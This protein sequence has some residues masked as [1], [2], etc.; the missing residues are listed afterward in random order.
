MIKLQLKELRGINSRFYGRN[1]DKMPKLIA[2]GRTPFSVADLM[3]V[4]LE[5]R[6]ASKNVRDFWL[7]NYF[8]TI[9]AMANHPNGRNKALLGVQ[10]LTEITLE[11]ESSLSDGALMLADGLYKILEGVKF[12]KRDLEKYASGEWQ[13]QEQAL[14]NRLSRVFARHPDEVPAEY[15]EDENLLPEYLYRKIT[16]D[17]R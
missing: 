9:D 6:T 11:T 14:G 5:V 10:Q 4:R 12:S 2:E 15:A 16:G 13:T 17:Q 1:I 7:Y 3:K 8:D